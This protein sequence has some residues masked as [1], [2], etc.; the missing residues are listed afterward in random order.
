MMELALRLA[1]RGLGRTWPNPA[2][3]C[4]IARGDIVV[5]RGWT[6]PGGRPHAE[7]DAL[8][9]AGEAAR[10][11]TAF[12]T[13]EPCAHYGKTP[14]CAEALIDAGI[15]R[16]VVA[17]VDSNPEVDGA[18]LAMLREAGIEVETGAGA[19]AARDLNAGFFSRVERGRPIVTLKVALT[20]DGRT[21]AETGQSKWITGAAARRRTHLLRATHDAILVG[22]A[23]ALADDPMLTCRLPGMADRSPV[24]IV[25][26][27][28]R[29]LHRKLAL[30]ESAARIPTWIFTA[31]GPEAP[32]HA[33]MTAAGAEVVTMNGIG[34]GGDDDDRATVDWVLGAVA[35][36]G[37]TRVLV[38]GGAMVATA[39]LKAAAVDRLMLFR[40]PLLFGDGGHPAVTGLGIADIGEAPAFDRLSVETI[41]EDIL[42]TYRARD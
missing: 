2:V 12:V 37:V 3:G 29:R 11:A 26:D 35:E 6:Q 16:V 14:P 24:R 40:A 30:I 18:G 7:T 25:L 9:R 15:A 4:V 41:G 22:S 1:A 42:E 20:L 23:T 28:R 8:D 19:A 38:E 17:T 13:L 10:G 33:E 32:W 34:D 31:A 36:R 27:R 39:F 21:A 5:G